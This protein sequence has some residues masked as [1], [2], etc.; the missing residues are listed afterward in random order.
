MV[1]Y[2]C[3]TAGEK[4]LEARNDE[5]LTTNEEEKGSSTVTLVCWIT[6]TGFYCPLAPYRNNSVQLQQSVASN[7]QLKFRR[8][9]ENQRTQESCNCVTIG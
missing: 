8:P 9:G 5:L 1:E 7:Y 2:F 4:E 6:G 3:G